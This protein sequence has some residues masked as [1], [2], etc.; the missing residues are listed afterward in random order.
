MALHLQSV[1]PSTS[2]LQ[3]GLGFSLRWQSRGASSHLAASAA[4]DRTPAS[5]S[6]PSCPR[7][8]ARGCGSCTAA[9]REEATAAGHDGAILD[10]A[11]A[12]GNLSS[13][14]HR[15]YK[16]DR[17]FQ[18]AQSGQPEEVQE[19]DS[20]AMM[21]LKTQEVPRIL[22]E[23]VAKLLKDFGRKKDLERYGKYLH[24][25]TRS[26]TSAEPPRLLSSMFL[27]EQDDDVK[28]PIA[29]L[30]KNPAFKDLF[31]HAGATSL[32][33]ATL[34]RLSVAYS[35]ERRH[36]L[37]QMFW[38]PEAAL[39]YLAHKYPAVW[40]SNY[41]VLQEVARRAP[42][43]RPRRVLDY[44]AGP[45]PSLA[46]AAEV[47]KG[48]FEVAAAVEPSENMSQMG[49][50]LLTDLDLPEVH[51]RRALYDEGDK[52]DL[53]IASFVQMEVRGQDSRDALVRQ[54]WNRLLPGGVLVLLEPGTPTGFRFM[55]HTRE[56][57]IS[58]I[59]VE[60]FHFIAPCQHEGMCPL[61]LTG[62]E[63][64]HFSQRVKRLKPN[65]YCKGSRG[66]DLEEARFSFL[67]I[68]KAPGPRVKYASEADAPTIHEKSYFWPRILFPVIKAGQHAHID[69]CSAPQNFERLIVSK[70]RPHTLGYKWSRKAMWGDLFRYP[71]RVGRPEARQY[72]PDETRA[73]LDRLAKK[74]YKALKWEESDASFEDL[75][76]QDEQHYGR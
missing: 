23:K 46:V 24:K 41:R 51:W 36:K 39:T 68:R 10:P 72:I 67:A 42:D 7:K 28:S 69:V 52:F 47:W 14:L 71:K 38:S 8:A 53:I 9:S 1:L 27:P 65:L 70:S 22:M 16:F 19:L 57:F 62:R 59:G 32:D 61:A 45:A 40:A 49:A 43:F 29:K 58:R 5:A 2:R 63:W 44:G 11:M 30:K 17:M 75:K 34:R 20:V 73:H 74:A 4:A 76:E 66:R 56:L 60:H 6:S 55:H 35:E 64:C 13:K 15:G 33:D 25:K 50:F 48:G 26:R 37:F 21:S 18:S 54:L 31:D 12:F 3:K